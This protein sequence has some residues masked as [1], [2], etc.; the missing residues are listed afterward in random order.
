M[1]KEQLTLPEL[2]KLKWRKIES[3]QEKRLQATLKNLI[4]YAPFYRDFFEEH[5]VDPT[6][7]KSVKDWKKLGLPLIKK[8]LYLD[9]A[10]DFIVRPQ[11]R[12]EETFFSYLRYAF[13]LDK[14]EAARL[15]AAGLLSRLSVSWDQKLT[16]HVRAFFLPKMLAFAGGTESG[17]PTPVLLTGRQ[18]MESM[19]NTADLSAYLVI[20]RHFSGDEPITG[21]NLFPYAPHIAW[22]I[23]NMAAELRTDLNLCTASGGFMGTDKLVNIAKGSSPNVFSGMVDYLTNIFLPRAIMDG[24]KLHGRVVFLNGATKMLEVQRQRVKELFMKLGASEV[25]ALDGYGASEL[26][27][28]TLAECEEGSGLH[29]VAPL[30]NIIRTVKVGEADPKSGYIYD[31]DFA[32]EEEEGYAAIW[33]IDGA[34]TLLMGFLLGD[35][36]EKMSYDKCPHCGLNVQRVYNVN[37]IADLETE[38][39]IQGIA[40]EKIHGTKVDLMGLRDNLLRIKE[41]LEVQLRVS[42]TE[43]GD[44]LEVRYVAQG[45]HFPKIEEDIRYMFERCSEV[46]PSSIE[47]VKMSDLYEEKELK[48]RGIIK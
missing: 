39:K 8:N 18:K 2:K 34:G 41:I 28:A 10:R 46:K 31:W 4:Q 5:R 15:V 23:I 1:L 21:M 11:G 40:E 7:I 27:E 48:F 38:L 36:Y 45:D 14:I 19:V 20:S 29:H 44:T 33:N 13:D 17:R 22:Q 37:R 26:K 42:H 12:R 32:G 35:S 3:L 47:R 9:R 6:R 24:V 16:R 43:C 25:I 30:S